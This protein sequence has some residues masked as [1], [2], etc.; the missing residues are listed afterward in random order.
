[1]K[2]YRCN[3]GDGCHN[4]GCELTVKPETRTEADKGKPYMCVMNHWR[5]CL[6]VEDSQRTPTEQGGD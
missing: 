2:K 1:M 5:A 6:W 3:G 4:P